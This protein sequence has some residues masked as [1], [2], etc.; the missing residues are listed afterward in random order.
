MLAGKGYVVD[1]DASAR[2]AR[3]PR[4]ESFGARHCGSMRIHDTK[5]NRP[6][7]MYGASAAHATCGE[8]GVVSVHVCA[9]G[10]RP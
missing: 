4:L 7:A 10:S 9:S 2:G 8:K 3:P 1:S 6:D 5:V